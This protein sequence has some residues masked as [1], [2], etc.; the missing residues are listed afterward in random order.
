MRHGGDFEEALVRAVNDTKDNDTVAA[1]VG[2][3]MGALHGKA[4]IPPRWIHGLSGRITDRDDGR[5]PELIAEAKS[6][7]WDV[8]VTL[9]L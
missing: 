9:P 4:A 8:P 6:T 1:I 5:I 7:F 2:A 3:A